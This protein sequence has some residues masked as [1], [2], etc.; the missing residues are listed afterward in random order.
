MGEDFRKEWRDGDALRVGRYIFAQLSAAELVSRA[1]G[2]LKA[3]SGATSPVAEVE[4]V[5]DLS[6]DRSRWFDAKE[7]FSAVRDLTLKEEK[8]P[9]NRRYALLLYVAEN[10]A[11]TIYNASRQSAPFD[12]DSPFW[13]P[14]C[15]RD[16]ARVV[17]EPGFED[18]VW[19]EIIG[20]PAGR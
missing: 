15:A 3:C 20:Q 18:R 19:S 11:K 16:L 9:T 4:H 14:L 8:R 13:I 10:V 7:A 6:K 17:G 5:L 2:V 1:V 12:E